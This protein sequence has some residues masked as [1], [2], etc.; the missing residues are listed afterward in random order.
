MSVT[1]RSGAL[2]ATYLP[3]LGM[4][5]SSLLLKGEELLAQRGG[6]EAYAARGSTF[7][8][9]LL[10]PWANRLSGWEYN[11]G[12]E[13]VELRRDDPLMHVDG[14]TGLP[15]H[16]V[17]GAS[18]LWNVVDTSAD[19]LVAELDFG[20]HPELL[21]TFPFPHRLELAVTLSGDRLAVRLVVR[22]TGED[23][24]PISFGF[25]PYLRCDRHDAEIKLPVRRRAVLDERGL[26]TGEHEDVGAGA[27]DGPLGERT[28]DDCFDE[29]AP[30]AVFSVTDALRTISIEF[31]CGWRVAQVYAP[32]GSDFICCEPMTAPVDALRS[33]DGLR[34]VAPGE[35]FAAEFAISIRS[36]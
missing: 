17:L 31:V 11:A 21:A 25:H 16:G 32:D 29:L 9:P 28:F 10:Y 33:G 35:R 18:P 5:C 12:G 14:A 22:P 26:P 7:G 3:E 8:I 27:L 24:V 23:P 2:A 13:H 6:P 19:Q 15:I 20:A 4:V 36:R 30:E 34:W 1:L